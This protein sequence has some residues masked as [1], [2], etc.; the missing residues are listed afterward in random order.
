MTNAI[1]NYRFEVATSKLRARLH[2]HQKEGLKWLIE[3]DMDDDV[4]G[5]ILADEMGLGKTIQTISFILSTHCQ[6]GLPVLILAD[7]GLMKQWEAEIKRFSTLPTIVMEKHAVD[8]FSEETIQLTARGKI[9]ICPYSVLKSPSLQKVRFERIILDEAHK[10][11]NRKSQCSQLAKIMRRQARFALCLTGTPILKNKYDLE[12]LLHFIGYFG[13]SSVEGSKKYVLRRTFKEIGEHNA[14]FALPALQTRLHDVELSDNEKIIYNELIETGRVLS[15]AREAAEGADELREVTNHLFK[16]ILRL[17]QTV[18]SQYLAGSEELHGLFAPTFDD[19]GT[20]ESCCICLEDICADNICKTGCNHVT[21]RD[22]LTKWC[23][24]S[25]LEPSCPLC[26]A[27]I[28]PRSIRIP[29]NNQFAPPSSKIT[30]L[31]EILQDEVRRDKAIIFCHWKGEM[32]EIANMLSHMGISWVSISGDDDSQ[33]RHQT[34]QD[35]QERDGIK[36]LLSMIQISA[37]GLNITAAKHCIFL[38]LDWTP[39]VHMQAIARAHRLGQTGQVTAHFISARGT[40]DEHVIN[41]QFQKLQNFNNVF[42]DPEI[43]TKMKAVVEKKSD[44]FH[45]LRPVA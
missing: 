31:Q 42:E 15:R 11:R 6:D 38:S 20:T 30:K 39:A 5:A 35:F 29:Y 18:V 7:K 13:A 33:K 40:I 44:L 16:I 34:V 26:R 3:R 2:Q 12:S 23:I 8:S 27:H 22:C 10:I 17:Q 1:I 43:M 41:K 28:Q 14:R 37:C 24:R 45:I 4:T 19:I 25:S 21:C 9:L 32:T 36:V